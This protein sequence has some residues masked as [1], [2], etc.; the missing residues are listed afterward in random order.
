MPPR[1]Q[2]GH[3]ARERAVG[4]VVRVGRVLVGEREGRRV[5][6][7]QLLC[8]AKVVGPDEAHGRVSVTRTDVV[9]REAQRP[10]LHLGLGR[11][12]PGRDVV[13]EHAHGLC[14]HVEQLVELGA[15][16]RLVGFVG[17]VVAAR[18]EGEHHP[19]AARRAVGHQRLKLTRRV[20]GVRLAPAVAVVGVVLGPVH[21]RVE[22]ARREEVDH[23]EAR[24]VRVGLAVEALDDPGPAGLERRR[25]SSVTG[26]RHDQRDGA[27]GPHQHGERSHAAN[28]SRRHAPPPSAWAAM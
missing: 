2:D 14:A 24:L 10:H 28:V 18:C 8:R 11:R 9:V 5:A 27:H 7:R 19:H 3:V 20:G 16:G 15:Q 23:L 22:A 1:P 26:Q 17:G 4:V 12:R 21:V 6:R 25:C 13:E